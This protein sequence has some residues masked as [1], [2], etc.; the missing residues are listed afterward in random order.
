MD[1]NAPSEELIAYFDLPLNLQH[2][3]NIAF[4]IARLLESR[5]Y[6]TEAATIPLLEKAQS[7]EDLLLPYRLSDDDPDAE[8]AEIVRQAAATQARAIVA[9]VERVGVGEDRLGQCLRNLF[10]CMEM[11]PRGGDTIFARRGEPALAATGR[12]KVNP[13]K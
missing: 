9:E 10:E 11:G 7:L 5:G 4:R 12:L 6:T 13:T 2:A 8:E 1:T 3:G